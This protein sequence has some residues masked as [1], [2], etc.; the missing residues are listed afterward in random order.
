MIQHVQLIGVKENAGFGVAHEGVIGETVPKTRD[1][2]IKL[3]RPAIA[4][5]VIDF[6]RIAKV[7]CSVGIGGRDDIPAGAAAANLVQGCEAPRNMIWLVER[8]GGGGDQPDPLRRA[9]ERR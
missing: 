3:A 7:Q 4:L 6:I 9:G 2:V 5:I 8:R 1:D